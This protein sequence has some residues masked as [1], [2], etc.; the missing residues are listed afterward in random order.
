MEAAMS[1]VLR[2]IPA[3]HKTRAG[4]NW[5]K[6]DGVDS[7]TAFARRFRDVAV[8]LLRDLGITEAQLSDTQKIQVRNAALLTAEI[9]QMHAKILKG[10]GSPFEIEMLIRQQGLLN[11]LHWGLGLAP[12]KRQDIGPNPLAYAEQFKVGAK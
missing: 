8:G 3:K 4:N 2:R 10:D 7:R 1:A 6:I 12:R 11:R 5:L 9:E